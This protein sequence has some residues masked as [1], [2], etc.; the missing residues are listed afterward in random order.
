MALLLSKSDFKVA[1]NCATKL[2]YKKSGYPSIDAENAYLE[3]L[4]EGGFMAEKMAK[5]LF[6]EGQEM[7][8]GGSSELAGSKTMEALRADNVTLF[9]ATLISAGKLARVDILKKQARRLR[10]SI[11]AQT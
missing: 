6:S 4:A 1:R 11:G 2:F 7:D 9:E 10:R 3:L 8:F 5:L